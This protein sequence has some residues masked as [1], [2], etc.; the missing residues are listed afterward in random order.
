VVYH[1]NQ[2]FIKIKLLV[3]VLLVSVLSVQAQNKGYINDHKVM[4]KVLAK[5]YGIPA[6]VILAVA[7]VESSGGMGP[8]ARVLHNHFGIEGDNDFVNK[9]GHSSRY[10]EYP[11][12]LAS[13]VDFCKLITRKHFYHRLKGKEDAKA[14]IMA[15]SRAGYSE[16]PEEWAKKVLG[17]LATIKMPAFKLLPAPS[18]ASAK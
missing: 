10:K 2:T 7:A 4:A 14:W 9:R 16:V 6:P 15:M 5:R 12:V 3:L 17:V 18:L 13:Y 1:L 8:A 11:N